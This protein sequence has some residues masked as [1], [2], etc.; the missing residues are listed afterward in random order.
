MAT[1]QKETLG[2]IVKSETPVLVDFY[3]DW[4][5]PCK[6]M[7]PVLEQLHQNLGGKVRILKIDIDRNPEITS[8][9][10]ISGVPTLILFKQGVQL[11]RQSGVVDAKQLQQV[12]EQKALL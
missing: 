6:M 9:L 8:S 5:G 4:C 7:K 10:Q 3:A 12:I 2:D 1:I 11:W